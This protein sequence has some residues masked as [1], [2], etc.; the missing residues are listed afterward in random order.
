MWTYRVSALGCGCAFRWR[1][2]SGE[3]KRHSA[4]S[5]QRYLL[6]V[7]ARVEI[8][9][10]WWLPRPPAPHGSVLLSVCYPDTWWLALKGKHSTAPCRLWAHTRTRC[11][12]GK[13]H[14]W[15]HSC[16]QFFQ[17]QNTLSESQ[18]LAVPPNGQYWAR[19]RSPRCHRPPSRHGTRGGRNQRDCARSGGK[20]ERQRN[21]KRAERKERDS[22]AGSGV[23]NRF[24]FPA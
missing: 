14:V 11:S 9:S 4:L 17:P 1:E 10:V 3:E 23:W 12:A 13:N 6:L 15:T 8:I 16:T 21:R 20:G 24:R 5:T 19:P 7:P 22:G 2:F 18:A